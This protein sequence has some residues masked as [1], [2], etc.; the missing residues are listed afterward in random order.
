M[1]AERSV[2]R[3]RRTQRATTA[4]SCS[5]ELLWKAGVSHSTQIMLS[6]STERRS[7]SLVTDNAKCCELASLLAANDDVRDSNKEKKLPF[8]FNV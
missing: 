8:V 3:S 6:T 2:T 1:F 7:S 4:G 5:E